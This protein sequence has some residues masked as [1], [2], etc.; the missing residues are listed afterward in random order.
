M[1]E[2]FEIVAQAMEKMLDDK[3]D[4]TP[5]ETEM[6]R[7]IRAG[8]DFVSEK[9]LTARE[10]SEQLYN[11]LMTY[12]ISHPAQKKRTLIAR[13]DEAPVKRIR[14]KYRYH[15]MLKLFDHP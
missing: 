14:G 5:E 1:T 3:K 12:L 7:M 8:G 2:R 11:T 6:L 9:E 4:K 13:L 15:V 10:P